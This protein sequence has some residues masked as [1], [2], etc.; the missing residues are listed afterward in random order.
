[1]LRDI[2]EE[3]VRVQPDMELVDRGD[4]RDVSTAIK[5]RQATVAVVAETAD[6]SPGHGALLIE[7]P[8]L[9]VLVVTH[10]GREAHFLEF[11][12]IPVA[13]VSPRGLV[14]AIRAAVGSGAK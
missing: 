5:T 3:A 8:R 12:R 11:R 13:D 7:N 14:D 10:D 4:E 6:E 9:K 1:M 2:V